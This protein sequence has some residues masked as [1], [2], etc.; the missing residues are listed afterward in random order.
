M[1]NFITACVETVYESLYDVYVKDFGRFCRENQ[2]DVTG[3]LVVKIVNF[4][5]MTHEMNAYNIQD[6]AERAIQCN[7]NVSYKEM[8]FIQNSLISSDIVSNYQNFNLMST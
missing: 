6:N 4:R 8:G 1:C 7:I 5:S 3:Y 2:N